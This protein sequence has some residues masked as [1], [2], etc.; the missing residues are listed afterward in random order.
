LFVVLF[1][2]IRWFSSLVHFCIQYLLPDILPAGASGLA[3]R[4]KA[5]TVF[6][7]KTVGLFPPVLGGLFRYTDNT[8][9][10]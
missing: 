3:G 7:R 8:I 1:L 5:G 2:E 6:L 9:A 4:P 10:L